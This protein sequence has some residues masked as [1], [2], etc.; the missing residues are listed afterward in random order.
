MP[1]WLYISGVVLAIF[2][3]DPRFGCSYKITGLF[4]SGKTLFDWLTDSNDD[5]TSFNFWCLFGQFLWKDSYSSTFLERTLFTRNTSEPHSYVVGFKYVGDVFSRVI[6]SG[7]IWSNAAVSHFCGFWTFDETRFS[8]S[9][10]SKMRRIHGL[11]GIWAM[12]LIYMTITTWM[13][14]WTSQ[15]RA[16]LKSMLV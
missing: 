5:R 8:F 3:I 16:I 14:E 4:T 1:H 13:P 15:M 10:S 11:P 7:E 9:Y 12:A 2:G 6:N